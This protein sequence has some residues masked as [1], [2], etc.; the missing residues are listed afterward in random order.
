MKL[1]FCS[2]IFTN[3]ITVQLWRE[4]EVEAQL[5]L[6]SPLHW[7][8]KKQLSGA[9]STTM[10]PIHNVLLPFYSDFVLFCQHY[11]ALL[12]ISFSLVFF[13]CFL[14]IILLWWCEL[15]YPLIRFVYSRAVPTEVIERIWKAGLLDPHCRPINV[16]PNPLG[17]R[18]K[19][20]TAQN[21]RMSISVEIV[22]TKKKVRLW[23][24]N[25]LIGCHGDW[26]DSLSKQKTDTCL[27]KKSALKD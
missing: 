20:V 24:L 6:I 7:R 19:C 11:K 18:A 27:T 26:L 14:W 2:F 1:C 25:I 17:R 16:I 22:K 13:K 21:R 23:T 4:E 15:I 12:Y 8:K 10:V 5:P 9:Y 3:D